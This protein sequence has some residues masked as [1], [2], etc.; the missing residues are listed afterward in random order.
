MARAAS[1]MLLLVIVAAAALLSPAA[2]QAPKCPRL[3]S[4]EI[5]RPAGSE[6]AFERA[7][8]STRA[9]RARQ[10]PPHAPASY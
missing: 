2:A 5:V 10:A 7:C 6:Q 1:A 4:S 8:A 3:A 9:A